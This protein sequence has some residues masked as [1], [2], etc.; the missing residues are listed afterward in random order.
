MDR[1]VTSGVAGGRE[2]V[3]AP[4]WL[5]Q[6]WMWERYDRLRPPELRAPEFPVSNVRVLFWARRRRKTTHE[7]SLRVLQKEDNCFEWRP[8]LHNSLNWTEPEWFSKETVLV[9]SRGKDKPEWLEDYLAII[10]QAALTGLCGDGMYNTAMYNPHIVAR[11]LGYDQD[12]PFPIVHGFD[13]KGIEV[14]IPGICRRG[15]ASKEYVA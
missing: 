8:Y 14:W 9:S 12:V 10:R 2:D 13:S 4:L 7:E 1:I 11:Q 5:L 6:A 3:W 15:L